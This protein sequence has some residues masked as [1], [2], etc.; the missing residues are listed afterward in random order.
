LYQEHSLSFGYYLYYL[1]GPHFPP[2]L[3]IPLLHSL[4]PHHLQ[5]L[6]H[7]QPHLLPLPLHHHLQSLL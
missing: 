2:P 1:H 7:L 4:H 3:H 6:P 5:I